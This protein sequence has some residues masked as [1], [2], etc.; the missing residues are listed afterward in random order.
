MSK[1]N[2][3]ISELLTELRQSCKRMAVTIEPYDS[4]KWPEIEAGLYDMCSKI[5]CVC[6]SPL[7]KF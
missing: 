2:P 1:T 7:T 5:I 4:G 3:E 6:L